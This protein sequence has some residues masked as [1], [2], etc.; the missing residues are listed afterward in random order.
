MFGTERIQETFVLSAQYRCEHKTALKK[1][2]LI[3]KTK[4]EMCFSLYVYFTKTFLAVLVFTMSECFY[5]V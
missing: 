5:K 1:K 3:K 2:P 4:Q